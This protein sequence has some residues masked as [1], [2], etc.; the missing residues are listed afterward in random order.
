MTTATRMPVDE[1]VIGDGEVGMSG[2][3]YLRIPL[4]MPISD[5]ELI[6]I[7]DENP[8]WRI[9]RGGE[10]LLEAR[11]TSSK[12]HSRA[13]VDLVVQVGMWHRANGRPGALCDSDGTYNMD[14][15]EGAKRSWA[16]DASWISA[17]RYDARSTRDRRG[18]GFWNLVPD[19]VIEVRSPGDSVPFVRSRMELWMHFGVRLGWA[20]DPWNGVVEV[21]RPGRE[22]LVLERPDSIGGGDVLDG[23]EV[24]FQEIWQWSDESAEVEA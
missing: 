1:R 18:E 5:D 13:S 6:K 23:L 4:P 15:G 21:Y 11:M 10:C 19:F 24:D 8:G 16:P 2:P 17:E 20:V 7:N 14:D 9:E 3:G 12:L 22:P